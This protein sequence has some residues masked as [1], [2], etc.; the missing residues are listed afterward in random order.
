MRS[1]ISSV[2]SG[3]AVKLRAAALTDATQAVAYSGTSYTSTNTFAKYKFLDRYARSL[4]RLLLGL[5]DRDRG[6]DEWVEDCVSVG[7]C[8]GVPTEES[9]A[10]FMLLDEAMLCVQLS[11]A[12]GPLTVSMLLSK[13]RRDSCVRGEKQ[14]PAT[15][16]FCR[17]DATLMGP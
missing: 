16:A 9:L 1:C 5:D 7:G 14:Q 15:S 8:Q 11:T 3:A 4:C 13:T 17:F 2:V 10:A 6:A 12:A